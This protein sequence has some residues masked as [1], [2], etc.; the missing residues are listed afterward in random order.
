MLVYYATRDKVV[1]VDAQAYN[2][3][4][5]EGNPILL[6]LTEHYKFASM[7]KRLSKDV[8]GDNVFYL[9][10]MKELAPEKRVQAK[11]SPGFFSANENVVL[12][13]LDEEAFPTP[14]SLSFDN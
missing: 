6:N 11:H 14:H 2:G 9:P 10:M 5:K 13:D 3:E 12:M 4:T 8:F 1:Y 7:V